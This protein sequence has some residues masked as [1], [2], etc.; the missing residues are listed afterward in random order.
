MDANEKLINL[1]E[2]RVRE[3]MFRYNELKKENDDLYI[4]LDE[5]EGAIKELEATIEQQKSDYNNLKLARMIE[6]H[7]DELKSAKSRINKLVR[8]IDKCI[9]LLNV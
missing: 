2:A 6:I 5:K 4:L 9:A 7:D 1:F 3:L 8:D